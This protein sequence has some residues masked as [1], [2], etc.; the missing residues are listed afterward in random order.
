MSEVVVHTLPRTRFPF[1]IQFFD[2]VSQE[3]IHEITVSTPGVLS[4]PGFGPGRP[5]S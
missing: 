1:T 2:P 5:G 3:V 4:V